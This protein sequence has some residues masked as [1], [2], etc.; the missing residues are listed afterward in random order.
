LAEGSRRIGKPAA[1]FL[2]NG[3]KCGVKVRN[4][5]AES[6]ENTV[7]TDFLKNRPIIP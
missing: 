6:L 7:N 2:R 4:Q 1:R 3:V 5:T